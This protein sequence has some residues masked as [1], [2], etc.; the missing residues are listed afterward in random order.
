MKFWDVFTFLYF[1]QMLIN[2]A[3]LKYTVA[4]E[5]CPGPLSVT[6]CESTEMSEAVVMEPPRADGFLDSSCGVGDS[7]ASLDDCIVDT[8]KYVRA[9]AYET[10]WHQCPETFGFRLGFLKSGHKIISYR[11][12]INTFC[13]YVNF[14]LDLEDIFLCYFNCKILIKCLLT[15]KII[16]IITVQNEK[17]TS[18]RLTRLRGS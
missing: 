1:L 10:P 15:L 6:L 14:C 8:A 7:A 11:R 17:M 4:N 9:N 12:K 18:T 5:L 2:D 3:P 13:C 16:Q